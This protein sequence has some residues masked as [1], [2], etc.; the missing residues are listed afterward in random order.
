MKE[1]NDMKV[2]IVHD[3][4]VNYGGAERVVQQF[5]M[6]YPQAD[7]FTLVYDKKKM[8]RYFPA[9][10][11]HVSSL[12]KFPFATKIYTKLLK[13]MP[14]AFEE[15]DFSNYDLV[16]ASSS[17]CAKGVITPPTVPFIA[18]IHTPMRYAW[19]L[20]NEYLNKSGIATKFFMRKWIPSIRQWDF[21]SSQRIDAIAANSKYVSRRIQ[22]FWNRDSTVIYPPVD[23]A[24]LVPNGLG[25]ENFYVVFSRF[26]PYKRIDLAIEACGRLDKQLVVIG[27]G[28]QEKELKAIANKYAHNTNKISFTGRISDSEVGNYLQRCKALIFCA[29][30]DFGIIP[31]EAQ[32]CGRPV[33]AFGKGGALETILENKTGIFFYEQTIDSVISA[34][35]RFEELYAQKQFDSTIIAKHAASFSS[36]RFRREFSTLVMKTIAQIKG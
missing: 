26:V 35:T 4:L 10:K 11:V 1:V 21:I 23:T 2:A 20:Y 15:F 13:F 3:W 19:D 30:E 22:K 6:L 34:M 27:S 7:I 29:D 32:A 31:V 24:R 18:Y 33:I 25:S 9:D 16:I 28:S 14:A 12:N 5:L 17:S 36:E 8:N